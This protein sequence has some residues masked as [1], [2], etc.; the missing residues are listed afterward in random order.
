MRWTL[1]VRH[2]HA[3]EEQR[4]PPVRRLGYR[5]ERVFSSVQEPCEWRL[6]RIVGPDVA[7]LEGP[8]FRSR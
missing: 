3:E 2:Y 8:P 5:A 7:E 1:W 6:G 4:T